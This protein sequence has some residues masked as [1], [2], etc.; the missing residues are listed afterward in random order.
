MGHKGTIK[1]LYAVNKGFPEGVV[2]KM[3]ETI[4]RASEKF[5]VT[6]R[7]RVEQ[8]TEDGRDVQPPGLQ[9]VGMDRRGGGKAG[10]LGESPTTSSWNS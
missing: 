2:E 10:G 5:L 4:E 7:G 6:A 9:D 1:A 3:R 8:R